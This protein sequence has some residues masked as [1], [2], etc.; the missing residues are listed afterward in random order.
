METRIFENKEAVAKGFSAYLSDLID[1]KSEIHIALSGGSTPKIVFDELVA[2]YGD[3]IDWKKVYFYWGD[4]RCVPPSDSESNFKMTQDHLLSK[5]EMPAENVHR[6][7]GENDPSQEAKR[8]SKVLQKQLPSENGMPR[9][10]LVILGMGD[11]GHTASIFP[12]SIDQWEAKELCVTVAHPV[13]GQIR[14][15]LSGGIINHAETVAFLVTGKSKAEK[16]R[17]VIQ[18]EGNFNSYPASLVKPESGNLIWFLD[19]DAAAD[20]R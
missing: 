15:S 6:I 5:I 17:E 12:D 11:D 19:E 4:E 10:D 14:V 8:Y 1:S 16:V 2:E 20:L 7:Q 13:S 3:K 9:F 18:K